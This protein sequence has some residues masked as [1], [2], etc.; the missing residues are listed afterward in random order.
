MRFLWMSAGALVLFGAAHGACTATSETSTSTGST[1]AAT[2]GVGG[3]AGGLSTSSGGEG[4][5]CIGDSFE[6][7]PLPLDILIMLDQSGSM[8]QSA[9]NNLTK[10]DTVEQAITAFVQQP[11]LEGIS[12]ALQYFG[13]PQPDI[14]GCW[15]QACI[16]DNDCTNGCGPCGS[17]GVCQVQFNPDIDSCD[18]IDYAWAEVPM[19][20]LPGVGGTILSSLAMHAP[21]TNTP[22][23]PALEGAIMYATNWQNA[24]PDHV[25]VVAFATDGEPAVCDT[26]INNI[27]AVAAAGFNGMPSIKTFVIGVGGAFSALDGIALYGGTYAA[28]HVD[29]NSMATDQFVDALNAIRNAALPCTYLIPPPPAGMAPD[30]TRVNVVYTPGGGA[31]QT[32]PKVADAAHCPANGLGWYYDDERAPTQIILCDGTCAL[33]KGDLMAKVDIVLG[34]ITI[35]A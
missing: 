27:Y 14:T 18:A 28:Y 35:V 29:L 10:W 22:T 11:N 20:P 3:A 23:K 30:F 6:A 17:N 15:A 21:G 32:I 31:E 34:C 33:I 16:T 26:D 9:G 2:V 24:H 12:L 7:E 5:A 8:S 4:G 25:T 19:Q 13:L 1:V